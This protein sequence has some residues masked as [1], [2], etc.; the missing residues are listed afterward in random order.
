MLNGS[1]GNIFPPMNLELYF[2]G[3]IFWQIEK[4]ITQII[5]CVLGSGLRMLSRGSPSYRL[6]IP[7]K[8][9]LG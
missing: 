9:C 2:I 8:G 6:P 7:D 4:V 3:T 5:F 1:I